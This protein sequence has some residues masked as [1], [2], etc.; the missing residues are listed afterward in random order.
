MFYS[1]L[2]IGYVFQM[3]NKKI[4]FY[5]FALILVFMSFFRYGIG[6][7]YF[8]YE[9]LFDRLQNSVSAEFKYGVDEQ[10]I[11]FRLIGT[12]LKNIGFTY[13]YY[14]AFFASIN[15]I[16]IVKICKKCSKNPTLSLF[17]FFSFYYVTW[18]LSGVRQGVVITV[19]LYYLLKY[20][21]E[22]KPLR[23]IAVSLLLS[24]IHSSA[25]V[26]ILF[27]FLSKLNFKKSTLIVLS[28]IGAIA[29]VV[30]TGF[31]IN[32][33]SWLPFYDRFFGYTDTAFALNIF[34]FQ[35][36]ARAVFLIVALI[37][38]DYYSEQGEMSKKII[39]I[40]ILSII[41]YFFLSFSELAAARLA[42]YGK[43]LD[44]I[45]FANVLYLYKEWINRLIYIVAIFVLCTLY[46]F[47]ETNA[48]I[49]E[50]VVNEHTIAPYVS[51]F[52]K[53]E[54][55]YKSEYYNLVD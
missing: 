42:I 13:Q 33:F 19:G 25:V 9:F 1:V 52:N 15:L 3:F 20:I 21:K 11:G 32:K 37:F 26:L 2:L 44:I 39:T 31:I 5:S 41:L 45:I 36:I 7:D 17:I 53:D 54:F 55:N 28:G 35:S 50:S 12:F 18:T 6:I 51:I 24:L 48:Q 29:S 30:P 27:Y 10:E 49:N 23:L 43:F 34:D 40:Y 47:K 46:L 4:L 8:A 22:N 14:L 16:Y 38:Y